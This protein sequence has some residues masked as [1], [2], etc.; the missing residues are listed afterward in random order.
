[1]KENWQMILNIGIF[2]NIMKKW[3]L[4]SLSTFTNFILIQDIYGIENTYVKF[5]CVISPSTCALV[6]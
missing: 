1:M 4:I 2:N 6:K 5:F 3:N